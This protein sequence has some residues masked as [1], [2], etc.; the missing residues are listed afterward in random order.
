VTDSPNGSV[1]AAVIGTLI[2]GATL[3]RSIEP[4]DRVETVMVTTNTPA[5]R[6]FPAKKQ[7]K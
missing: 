6:V 7:A 5:L 4:G 1:I 2:I 3:S